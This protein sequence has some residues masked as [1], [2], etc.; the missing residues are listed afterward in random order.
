LEARIIPKRIEHWI[1][2]EH[3]IHDSGTEDRVAVRRSGDWVNRPYLLIS[4][5]RGLLTEAHSSE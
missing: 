4:K 1:E 5:R 2:P 3:L